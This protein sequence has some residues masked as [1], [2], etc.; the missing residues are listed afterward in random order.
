MCA[1]GFFILTFASSSVFLLI[2]VVVAG[3]GVG[4]LY[5]TLTVSLM[6]MAPASQRG[7]VSGVQN[8]AWGVGYFVGPMV[9]GIV[10]T[11]SVSAPYIFCAIAAVVGG[12][13][14]SLYTKSD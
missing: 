10:A 4:A 6:N 14:T 2:A 1:L 9:G 7:L 3:L 8:I 13:L 5:V 11:Y 12:V